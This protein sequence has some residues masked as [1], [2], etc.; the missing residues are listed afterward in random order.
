ML[1]FNPPRKASS[2]C[3]SWFPFPMRPCEHQA[4]AGRKHGG[5]IEH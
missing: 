3:T 5:A 4:V 1:L 2:T